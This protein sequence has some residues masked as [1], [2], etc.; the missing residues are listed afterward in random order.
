MRPHPHL[1]RAAM[2]PPDAIILDLVLPDGSGADVLR[3]LRSWSS[4]PVI[5]LSAVGDEAEK[6]AALDAGADDFVTKPVGIDELLARLRASLR[7]TGP[8]LEPVITV[9]GLVVDLEKRLVTVDGHEVNLTPHQFE[10]LRVLARDA[11]KLVTHRSLLREV[12]GPGYGS[13]SNLLHV[14]V[15]QLRPVAATDLVGQI[16]PSALPPALSPATER[17]SPSTSKTSRAP[18]GPPCVPL[19]AGRAEPPPRSAG[20][21]PALRRSADYLG[22][23]TQRARVDRQRDRETHDVFS[24]RSRT[25]VRT[26]RSSP[27]PP[28]SRCAWAT[29]ATFRSLS[30]C[31]S[32]PA[33][34]GFPT[35]T[36][37]G[38]AHRSRTRS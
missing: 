29:P 32:A 11:G 24:R 18:A 30:P 15:S 22:N 9:G 27:R 17:F 31:N 3:E 21:R 34:S 12:W 8:S 1:R 14:H 13:E 2:R 4:A 37:G 10:I 38:D 19:H 6:I 23:E 25:R 16:P 35:A 36:A 20:P 5:V 33:G 26:S 7:R 28:R